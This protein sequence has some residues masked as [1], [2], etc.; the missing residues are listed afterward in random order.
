MNVTSALPEILAALLEASLR[1]AVVL[2]AA[3]VLTTLLRRRSAA[4]RHAIWAGAIT[5]QLL[6][7]VL[8]AWGPRW[9]VAAP[10][11]VS[12]LVPMVAESPAPSPVT[13][14]RATETPSTTVA[15]NAPDPVAPVSGAGTGVT[16]DANTGSSQAPPS[17]APVS[18][19]SGRTLLGALWL[20]G[21]LAVLLRLAIGTA[22]V[23][24][25]AR[26]GDRIA[27][28]GWLSLA[29]RLATT[30][31]IQRPLILMRGD[32]IGVPVTWG[33]VY[34]VVLLP[35]DA[36]SWP[37][38]RRRFV[39]VHEMAHV[40]RLDALT[41]L[42]G[43]LALALFWFD[44]L[45]WVATRRMQLER[46]HAC[47]DYVLRH[48]TQPSQYANDLLEMVRTLGTPEH[49]G[50]QPAFAALAMARRSEFEGRMLSILD[51]VLDRHPLSRGRTLMSALASLLVIVPLA[52]LQPYRAAP[53]A[54]AA[55]DLAPAPIVSPSI[56]AQT[57][58]QA[59]A[60]ATD[61]A[62]LA[63]RVGRLDSADQRLAHDVAVLDKAVARDE[64]R[65]KSVA[66]APLAACDAASFTGGR[67]RTSMQMHSDDDASGTQINYLNMQADRC[68]QAMIT[69]KVTLTPAEDD[70]VALG[71]GAR[72]F[73]RERSAT[74]DR[75]LLVTPGSGGALERVYRRNG[76]VAPFDADARRW[77]ARFLPVVMVE[78]GQNAVPRV[79]RWRAEGGT[80]AV[81]RHLAEVQSS[82]SKRAHFDA[83]LDDGRLNA[84]EVGR[85]V[86]Q[87]GQTIPSSGD[88]RAVLSKAAPQI[89][90]T[91]GSSAALE[92][93]FAKVA[94]S[95]DRT[96]VLMAYGQTDD[97]DMLLLVMR[98]AA[99]IPS[100]GDKSRL[101]T[102]LT[103]RYFQRED[104]ALR[105][106]FFRTAATIPS[107]GDLSGVLEH[108]VPFAAKSSDVALGV[109]TT[110]GHIASSGDRSRVLV[111]LADS[112]ALRSASLR[113]AYL[114]AAQEIPSS[115][116]MR[117]VL[118]ALTR[119]QQ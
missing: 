37:E 56:A 47:D 108:V 119:R 81:L 17:G 21:A 12:A 78:T 30:L 71:D 97:R 27:D 20:L 115:G 98:T 88:L 70:V 1:G 118:E 59:H 114:R 7:L 94:S 36:D 64:A 60:N 14:E 57:D 33:I 22:M 106:A 73:L 10:E 109:M 80:D 82:G 2:L 68:T 67:S 101:L 38:E 48:G 42:V 40:K 77:L 39:L 111:A 96:E 83:L 99:T 53:A 4:T 18:R 62:S 6:M 63:E 8:A 95:G 29:Q 104:A 74:D 107:S 92:E 76:A 26:Q 9:R 79:A 103:P 110:A 31:R 43:Q 51:P 46:E 116:D 65:V 24:R 89:R 23:A 3:L 15:T 16:V 66:A 25:L 91:S 85:V 11:A 35:D 58:T 54:L 102:T 75:S 19:P 32:R 28:G 86:R 50:A 100:S 113:D 117:R 61:H 69:G 45:V 84:A 112:G 105:D 41:Q 72:V 90:S 34:P 52:A 44:P 93:A 5:A 49:R 13:R 55:P 87:A